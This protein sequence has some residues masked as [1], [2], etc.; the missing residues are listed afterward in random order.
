M[1]TFVHPSIDD[2]RLETLL[3]A[4]GDKIRLRIIANLY[5][6]KKH[7][8]IC[9]VAT[10][11]IENLSPSTRS[12]HFRILREGGIIRS[13]KKGKECYNQL[14]IDELESKFPGV[15]KAILKNIA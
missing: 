3:Y 11:G 13:E 8:L 14:R 5:R 9:A 10:Q 6:E 4:L 2:L 1:K 7:P 12:Y 15:V